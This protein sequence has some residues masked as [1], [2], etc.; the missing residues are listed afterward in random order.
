MTF[1]QTCIIKHTDVICAASPH[2]SV[3]LEVY[4]LDSVHVQ[5]N[6][7]GVNRFGFLC[8]KSDGLHYCE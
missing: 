5:R 1:Y 8:S 2:A 4:L 3:I 7:L 6:E